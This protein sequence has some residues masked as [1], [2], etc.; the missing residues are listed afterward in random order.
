MKVNNANNQ[1][2]F[3]LVIVAVLLVVLI[4]FVA[5]A[6]DVGLL[7]SARTSA[8][9]VADSAALAG[10]FTFIS[11]PTAPQPATATLHAQQVAQ[12][13]SI[14][15][16]PVTAG[17]VAVNVDVPNRRVTVDVTSVQNTYFARALGT[18]TA[19]IGVEGIAEAASQ[20]TNAIVK[21]W[22]IPNTVL[23]TP[24]GD[25]SA[26]TTVPPQ[27]LISGN[28]PQLTAWGRSQLGA[29]FTLK[30]NN[31]NG[32][33]APGDFYGIQMPNDNNSGSLYRD[34]ISEN[35]NPAV[36]CAESYDILKGNKVGPTKQGVDDLIGNPARDK[37]QAVGQYQTPTGVSDVSD[38]LVS[39]PIWDSCSAAYCPGNNFPKG[40]AS[41]KIVGFALLF[42]DGFQ[43]SN[44]TAHL[45]DV[46]ACSNPTAAPPTGSAVLSLPLRLVHLP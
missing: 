12:N 46:T 13:N 34:N 20:A 19:N 5:L 32:A 28:P 30:P 11:S 29:Q 21:P 33:I 39:A 37:Y 4:G 38:A 15:G 43:G 1:Q 45:I 40:Q 9:E 18:N 23:A 31:P 8:Q 7:Y 24:K 26:C 17:N 44:L 27:V 2:G 16:Q 6:V 35:L 3:V 41:L 22:F 14:F 42:L 36:K 25:C 10:A